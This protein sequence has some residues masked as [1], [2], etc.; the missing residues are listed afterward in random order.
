MGRLI[1]TDELIRYLGFENTEEEREEN[2]GEIITLEMIDEIPT[3]YNFDEVLEQLQD[4][5]IE[6]ELFGICSDYVP[7]GQAIEIVKYGRK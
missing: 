3:A 1:D 5:A 6:F 2:V 4:N 7:L